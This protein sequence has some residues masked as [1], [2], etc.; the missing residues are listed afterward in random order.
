M[1]VAI[2]QSANLKKEGVFL[3][4]DIRDQKRQIRNAKVQELTEKT[5]RVIF[6]CMTFP[7]SERKTYQEYIV[8]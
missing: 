7:P 1:P 2:A 8:K 4:H 6:P 3:R 5:M